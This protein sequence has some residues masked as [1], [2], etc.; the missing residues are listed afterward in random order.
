MG[1]ELGDKLVGSGGFL[2]DEK[3]L[4]EEGE[5]TL[6]I[7]SHNRSECRGEERQLPVRAWAWSRSASP[8]SRRRFFLGSFGSTIAVLTSLVFGP[9]CH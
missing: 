7:G 5:E 4:T 1:R 8:S 9:Y 3:K 2:A 6:G